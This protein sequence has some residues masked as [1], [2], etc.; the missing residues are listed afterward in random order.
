LTKKSRSIPGEVS[1]KDLEN[2]PGYPA[3]ERLE[4]GPVAVIECI[5]KIPCNPCETACPSGA[6]I[7]GKPIINLPRL[8]EDKCKGCGLCIAPCPGLAI[9][10]VDKTY[11]ENKATVAFPYEYL[12]LPEKGQVVKGLN[13]KGEAICDAEVIKVMNIPKNKKTAVVTVAIPKVYSNQVRN[14]EPAGG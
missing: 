4:Q 12:P 13:R 9:F 10:V 6:I 5:E 2:C 7:V 1:L 8:V 14:I 3:E 11:S